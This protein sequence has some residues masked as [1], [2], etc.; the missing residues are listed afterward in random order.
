ML[1]E[2]KADGA[3]F[4][5]ADLLIRRCLSSGIELFH[6]PDQHGWASVRV[7]QHWENYPLRSRAFHLFMLRTYYL[8]TCESPG[9]QA[10][11]AALEIFEARALFDGPEQTIHLRVAEH[12]GKL[13]LDLCDPEWRAVE[14]DVEGWRIVERAPARFRRARGSQ[15][16]PVP[17]PG[18]SVEELRPFFNVDHGGWVLIKAFLVAALNPPC[19]TLSSLPRASRAPESRPDAG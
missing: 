18:G 4:S 15:P 3:E 13:Y 6:D 19:P 2:R 8:D 16:L 7:G 1:C 12:G 10:L 14:I 9:S 11:R 17:V 5:R